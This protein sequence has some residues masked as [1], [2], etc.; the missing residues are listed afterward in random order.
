MLGYIAGGVFV[1]APVWTFD[2]FVWMA[3]ATVVG[4]VCIVVHKWAEPDE[5]PMSD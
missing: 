5:D 1:I 3:G 2:G 4:L